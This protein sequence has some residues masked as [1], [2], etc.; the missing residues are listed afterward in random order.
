[1]LASRRPV[2]VGLL[3]CRREPYGGCPGKTRARTCGR[4]VIAGGA[5]AQAPTWVSR[6]L[7]GLL[8]I[9][10]AIADKIPSSC[11]GL[12]MIRSPW[13]NRSSRPLMNVS[14]TLLRSSTTAGFQLGAVRH[15]LHEDFPVQLGESVRG[16]LQ[17][18]GQRRIAGGLHRQ[19]VSGL[20]PGQLR[21]AAGLN[22][23]LRQ[24]R[25]RAGDELS[26]RPSALSAT[27][28][29]LA[30]SSSASRSATARSSAERVRK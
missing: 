14:V 26:P 21:L 4:P 6:P 29:K 20:R 2:N 22:H 13:A 10:A 27:D 30:R 24:L 7:S 12:S 28:C 18:R 19:L 17:N 16:L 11:S 8:R 1:M 23:H 5:P 3:Y 9:P 25:R 15:E